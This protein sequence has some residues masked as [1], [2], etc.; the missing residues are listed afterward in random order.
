MRRILV[1]WILCALSLQMSGQELWS[2]LK[3]PQKVLPKS[4]APIQKTV[5][6]PFREIPTRWEKGDSQVNLSSESLF[7]EFILSNG[8]LLVDTNNVLSL[9]QKVFNAVVPGTVLTTLVSQGV[10]PDPYFG[11]NNLQIPE[12]LNKH[13]WWYRIAF[14]L[15]EEVNTASVEGERYYLLFN[16]INYRAEVYLND[17]M[18]GTIDGAFSRGVFDVTDVLISDGKPFKYPHNKLAVKIIPP[19]HPGIPH[20]QSMSEGQGLNGGC[21]SLDGPTFIASMGWDWIPGI[22]DRNI[23]IW[24]DV[25]LIRGG[26][27]RLGDPAIITDLPLPDTTKAFVT[28]R[29]PVSNLSS[30]SVQGN[31]TLSIAPSH[32]ESAKDVLTLSCDYSLA[33]N[34]QQIIIFDP[35]HYSQLQMDHPSLWWPNGYGEPYL[36]GAEICANISDL[37]LS[38]K[39]IFNFGIREL[40]YE[41]MATTLSGE[42]VRLEY[43]PT[44]RYSQNKESADPL[45][46]NE[47]RTLYNPDR[48]IY[49]PSLTSDDM[50]GVTLLP[51]DDPVGENL[52]IKVNGVRIFCRGGNWGMDDAIKR[53]SRER[54]E[55]Y[56]KLQQQAHFNIIRNWTGESTEE[57][58]YTLCDEY[59]MLVW[60]DF[61]I[62]GDDTVGPLDSLLFMNNARETVL[63]FRNHPSI[64]IWCPRNE[65]FA[66]K[67]LEKPLA[68]L[69]SEN[70]VTR[71]YHGQSRFLN[72]GTSG[73]WNYFEDPSYYFVERAYGFNTEMGSFAI[74]TAST[75]RKFIAPEDLWPINDVWAYHDLHHTSQNFKGF[76]EAV[77]RD[78]EAHSMEEFSEKAQRVCYDAWRA[79][80]ESWNAKM[81]DNT[82]GLIL[83]MS[84]PAW[85]S[86]IWQTYTYDYQTPGSY[87]GAAKACEPVHIQLNIPNNEVAVINTTL[88]SF[89]NMK[90]TATGY[91]GK[92]KKIF[93]RKGKINLPE[94]N[95]SKCFVLEKALRASKI[96]LE[97]RDDKG[98]IVSINEY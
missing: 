95:I 61:W 82:T 7:Q 44:D 76:M 93:T 51:Q 43:D 11:L 15:P 74:P 9:E 73:P 22:R 34:E 59:G 40:S 87:M 45:F 10:F 33:P 4:N 17:K 21:M 31:I 56:F 69:I 24:Q 63:R 20:E 8:W 49:I 58:F 98:N 89:Q 18:I 96:V 97:L 65:A 36:Y 91:N 2:G 39:K 25:R 38:D 6:V 57:I 77:Y 35:A 64:A 41:L 52:V 13:D 27:V 14:D 47:N 84:H 42:V 5:R 72:M 50:S 70:D 29:V 68:R 85:P 75:I 94:N 60:N 71:H 26:A 62:T 19:F 80:I 78:G 55:P 23:G 37:S 88:H 16:G 32:Q 30:S 79:M 3:E 86:M 90:I 54:L 1:F 66:P 48:G 83:W 53:V 67:E 12:E 46:D 92:G 28:V 81:W